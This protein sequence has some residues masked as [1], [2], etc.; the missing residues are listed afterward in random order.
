[1]PGPVTPVFARWTRADG[2]VYERELPQFVPYDAPRRI[3]WK[4]V[5][6]RGM[7]IARTMATS[8]SQGWTAVEISEGFRSE[9][10]EISPFWVRSRL[11]E[12]RNELERLSA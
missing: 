8:A 2:Y 5:S 12:L 10:F 9:G 3:D 7:A 4:R 1:V 6:P 11:V